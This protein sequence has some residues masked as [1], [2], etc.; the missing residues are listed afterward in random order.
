VTAGGLVRPARPEDRPEVERVVTDAYRPWVPRI[1]RKPAPMLDDYGALIADG[2]VSVL[3]RGG[4]ILGVLVLLPQPETMLLDNVA[5]APEAQGSGIGR[6]LLDHAEAAARATGYATITLYTNEL[7][8]ENIAL[9]A[10]R[11]Y[12][13]TERRQEKGHRRVYMRKSLR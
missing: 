13:E 9:Y 4:S 2:R 6:L 8:P 1:G 3:E 5:V 11:G 10:R 12:V 7:M